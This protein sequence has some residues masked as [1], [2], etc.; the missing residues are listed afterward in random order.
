MVHITD[1]FATF[2]YLASDKNTTAIPTDID[3]LNVWE[4]ISD[5]TVSPRFAL[6]LFLVFAFLF[7][8]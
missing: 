5:N 2:I 4:S 3:G 1:L 6:I 7:M 8:T